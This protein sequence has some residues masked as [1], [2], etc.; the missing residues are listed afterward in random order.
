MD[1]LD[2]QLAELQLITTGELKLNP[3]VVSFFQF[4]IRH[5]R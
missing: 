3:N 1:D 2:K 5:Y 4:Y